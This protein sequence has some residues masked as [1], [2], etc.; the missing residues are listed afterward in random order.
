MA[1]YNTCSLS[2]C[3]IHLLFLVTVT[4]LLTFFGAEVL[5]F[6]C[7]WTNASLFFS[8]VISFSYSIFCCAILFL[9]I[10][11]DEEQDSSNSEDNL[12]ILSSYCILLL[13]KLSS[14]FLS[15]LDSFICRSS[16][17][18]FF[19]FKVFDIDSLASFNWLFCC[20]KL[21]FKLNI[22][23]REFSLR[24]SHSLKKY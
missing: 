11:I 13:C 4:G 20:F 21:E 14:Y 12:K 6:V 1:M 7:S 2:A 16:I 5:A 9:Y 19:T 22:F 17:S 23:L 18:L 3:Y 24:K 15:L 10:S 8:S